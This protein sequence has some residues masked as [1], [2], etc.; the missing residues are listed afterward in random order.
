MAKL[1]GLYPFTCPISTL[2]GIDAVATGLFSIMVEESLGRL[3]KSKISRYSSSFDV[4]VRVIG[5]RVVRG[6]WE[7]SKLKS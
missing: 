1:V 7:I 3:K 4:G 5:F 2:F 6:L